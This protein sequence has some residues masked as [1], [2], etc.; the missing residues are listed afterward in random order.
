MKKFITLLGLTL[1]LSACSSINTPPMMAQ[2]DLNKVNFS[3]IS[4]KA[5]DCEYYILGLIGPFGSHSVVE[6]AMKGDISK[7]IAADYTYSSK[8]LYANRCVVVYVK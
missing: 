8:I 5:E 3:E 1:S 7:V 4:K 2:L 6:A